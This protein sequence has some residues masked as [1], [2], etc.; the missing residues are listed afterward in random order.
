MKWADGVSESESGVIITFLEYDSCRYYKRNFQIDSVCN[1]QCIPKIGF[2]FG[3]KKT[4]LRTSFFTR[5]CILVFVIRSITIARRRN[6]ISRVDYWMWSAHSYYSIVW[7]VLF[8][9]VYSSSL[10]SF[11]RCK[12]KCQCCCAL[13]AEICDPD[14]LLER[15]IKRSC[16]G[17][18][19]FA[20]H[21]GKDQVPDSKKFSIFVKFDDMRRNNS[22]NLW[23][24][25]IPTIFQW[26]SIFI[27][28]F[29]HDIHSKDTVT[30]YH[31]L[32]LISISL[33]TYNAVQWLNYPEPVL[34]AI[35]KI[36]KS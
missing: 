20:S 30:E 2:V 29:F 33:M 8:R 11:G 16:C 10:S 4:Y 18:R 26:Y 3:P 36:S 14:F 23:F 1:H 5:W 13:T 34:G 25:N 31:V 28:R 12:Y 24:K 32:W 17:G 22:N 27:V 7:Y 15:F 21:T 6:E 9:C 19:A 35:P